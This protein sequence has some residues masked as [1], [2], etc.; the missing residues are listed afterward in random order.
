L[1]QVCT[2]QSPLDSS[3]ILHLIVSKSLPLKFL[4][5][6]TNGRSFAKQE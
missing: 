3:R 6:R 2:G 5:R 1:P 4:R